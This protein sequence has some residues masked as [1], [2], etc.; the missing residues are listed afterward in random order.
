MFKAKP[1]NQKAR[2]NAGITVPPILIPAT[3]P[4]SDGWVLQSPD[5]VLPVKQFTTK[6]R[7]ALHKELSRAV[8]AFARDPKAASSRL[9]DTPESRRL[10]AAGF[11]SKHET[12]AAVWF[13]PKLVAKEME[14]ARVAIWMTKDQQ[15]IP[16][17]LCPTVKAAILVQIAFKGV[18]VCPN[19]GS[20][21]VADAKR[22]RY[23]KTACGQ[24]FRQSDYRDRKR[25]TAK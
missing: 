11:D 25:R 14:K 2:H 23:C 8:K 24:A 4:T 15:F 5:V 9:I 17:I 22:S 3:E 1:L 7:Y 6:G 18:N 20:L 19:C 21:F 13:Y 10:F 12:T 16:A